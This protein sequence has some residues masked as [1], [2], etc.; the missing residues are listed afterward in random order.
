MSYF[1]TITVVDPDGNSADVNSSGAL[2]VDV[3]TLTLLIG[4][5]QELV[6]RLS[7]LASMVNAGAP[8]LRTIPI[9]SVSTAITGAVNINANQDLRTVATVTTLTNFGTSIP[10]SESANAIN[11][12][13]VALG[14]IN[15]V[16]IS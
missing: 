5:L 13:V 9:G 6:S 16:T 8:A 10:A 7:P 3:D 14:N 4:T 12:T 1:K 11:R 15:N 2:K